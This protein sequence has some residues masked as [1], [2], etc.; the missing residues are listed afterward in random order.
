VQFTALVAYGPNTVLAEVPHTSQ[1][2]VWS[3]NQ[4]RIANCLG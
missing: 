2:G 1:H 4:L 3:H